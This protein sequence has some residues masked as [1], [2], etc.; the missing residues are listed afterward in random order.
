MRTV[1]CPRCNA[2]PPQGARFCPQCGFALAPATAVPGERRPVAVLFAD[3]SGFT[4]LSN[5]LD[6]EEVHRILSRYFELVDA[7]VAQSGGSIDKHIGDA[8]MGVFGAPVAY[9]NDTLRA[10]R[11]ACDVHAAMST[12]SAEFRRPL[13]AHVGVASGEVVAADTGSSVHRNYTVTGDAVNLAARLN[14]LAKSGETVISDDVYRACTSSI[15][16]DA[17]GPV[18]IRGLAGEVPVWRLR[19]VRTAESARAAFIGR[20]AEIARFRRVL[21]DLQR[22]ARGTVCV[23]RADP[24]MGKTRLA[25]EFRDLAAQSGCA[26]HLAAVLDFG[27]AQRRDAVFALFA[28]LLGVAA[29]ADEETRALAL[30]R[31]L[32]RAVVGADDEP[33][34]ADLLAIAP[35]AQARYEAMDNEARTQGKLRVLVALA[36]R[37]SHSRPIVLFVEDVHW[38]SPWVLA[39]LSALAGCARTHPVLVVAT[40]RR[41]GEPTD[42]A[43]RVDASE[44]F[45]LPPLRNDD[46]L[47]LARTY[48]AANPDVARR[49]VERAQGIPL[50]L[51]QLLRSGAD[52]V[53]IPGTIQSVVLARLDRLDPGDKAALQAASVIG[54]RFHLDALRHLL[55]HR[56]FD[57]AELIERD[58]VRRVEDRAGEIMFVHALIRDGAY[59]SLLH[60]AR[61]TLHL[62][63]A[64]W[65]EGRDAS[66]HAEHL[67]RA[68]DPRAAAAYLDAARGEAAALRF[69]DAQRLAHRGSE[70]AASADVRY[71][72][73]RFEGD[74]A[75]DTGNAMASLAAFERALANAQTDAQRCCAY[76]GYASV[77]RATGSADEGL[78]VLDKVDAMAVTPELAREASRASYL[79]GSFEFALGN[80]RASQAAQERALAHARSAGAQDA[81]AEALSG[82]ADVLYADGRMHSSFAAFRQC[83]ALCDRHGLARFA[84]NNRC[85][86][87]VVH[88][89]LVPADGALHEAEQVR[90]VSRELRHRAAEVMADECIGWVYVIQGRYA[91]AIEPTERSL[92]LARAIGSRRFVAFDLSLLTYAYW[93]TGRE[94]EARDALAEGLAVGAEIGMGFLG[95]GLFGARA[96][97][98]RDRVELDVVL[99]EAERGIATGNPAHSHFWFRR[100]AIDALLKHGD[101]DGVLRQAAAL[102]ALTHAEA[103]PWAEFQVARARALVAAGRGRP[104]RAALTASRAEAERLRL[105]DVLPALDEAIARA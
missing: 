68:E 76:L 57:E 77:Y 38:A 97:M 40:T 63:A 51:T 74:L 91:Q 23:L 56:G 55:E 16:A 52:G 87:T 42:G 53:A 85:M 67:D 26:T 39:C 13:A 59:A 14:S 81:E 33:F 21:H 49:C 27:T 103:M 71:E 84:L 15:D 19:R 9:G 1:P 30:D 8:V 12:L 41:E 36:Q 101:Y 83:V 35:R 24:G 79:R 80:A 99:E 45:D 50:F 75:R 64:Q 86:L 17:L 78:A 2:D 102:E 72:L 7:L 60:S 92:A 58:L 28:S 5:E 73:A 43:W 48:L 20:D 98:A 4:A 93:H 31:A 29:D 88:S 47:A 62:R 65:Y 44:R 96:M 3:L 22:S 25:E 11:A 61:R 104:D 95:G 54:Q 32:A 94:A 70:L 69:D 6:A 37:V 89:Y 82:L 46:A 34:A 10:L 105:F 100:A 18:A 90:E 66:L